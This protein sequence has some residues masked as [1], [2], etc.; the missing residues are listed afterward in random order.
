MKKLLLYL[1]LFG[2]FREVGHGAMTAISWYNLEGTELGDFAG[3]P[4]TAGQFGGPPGDI[5]QLGYYTLATTSNPFAG[6]WV[7]LANGV[8]G[9]KA[10]TPLGAGRYSHSASLPDASQLLGIPL[11]I[12]FYD[13]NP[14]QTAIYFNAVADSTGAWNVMN[15]PMTLSLRGLPKTPN[16]RRVEFFS[17]G[18]SEVQR[19]F[20]RACGG[21]T[22]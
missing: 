11:S 2:C 8:I 14:L 6:S 5:I 7:S 4:L 22:S 16:S 20:H 13:D 21:F 9:G 15:T 3:I 19:T 10:V 1:L 12:R 18:K 17:R